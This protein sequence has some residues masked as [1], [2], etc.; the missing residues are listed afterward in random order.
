MKSYNE[1][2]EMKNKIIEAWYN[3][4]IIS[5]EEKNEL[6]ITLKE[7][8]EPNDFIDIPVAING[9]EST[10]SLYNR[11]SNFLNN[12][13]FNKKHSIFN[14]KSRDGRYYISSTNKKIELIKNKDITENN[15][16]H[17]VWNVIRDNTDFIKLT[18]SSNQDIVVDTR[19]NL[20]IKDKKEIVNISN[21]WKLKL[22]EKDNINNPNKYYFE[23][24]FN[25]GYR[26]KFGKKLS[27]TKGISANNIC[28]FEPI[29]ID[30]NTGT[31]KSKILLE[32]ENQ[33]KI[34]TNTDITRMKKKKYTTKLNN[35]LKPNEQKKLNTSINNLTTNDIEK[36]KNLY[37]LINVIK[38]Y[39]EE[40][41]S[42]LKTKNFKNARFLHQFKK[43]KDKYD[44]IKENLSDIN[45]RTTNLEDNIFILNE[46]NSYN[47]LKFKALY[48][49][50]FA[51][52]IIAL[53]LF[54]SI[55]KNVY[56]MIN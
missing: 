27:L 32:L 31:I 14:I 21:L 41:S 36:L 47:Y 51:F 40:K 55:G 12:P 9:N 30:V 28:I 43:D 13:F 1:Y 16:L 3:S 54:M 7:I 53:L 24:V 25:P 8:E 20:Q 39:L 6:F 29:D 19:K 38:T 2:I 50:R 33:L 4:G 46:N 34:F 5:L 56:K 10:Y 45:K 52:M 37:G 49:I 18:N 42:E 44:N 11:G 35:K 48:F 17:I 26:L 15:E 22:V 23:S